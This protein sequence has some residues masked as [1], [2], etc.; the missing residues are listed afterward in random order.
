MFPLR[1]SVPRKIF[2]FWTIAIILA[3][4]Y[5]FFLEL[6]SGDP[7][8]FIKQYALVP[9][10][11]NFSESSALLPFVTS[12]FIH[13]GFLHV[14]ANMLFLWVFGDNVEERL[15]FLLFPIFYILAGVFGGL[16][17]YFFIPNSPIPIIGASG[18][19][20]GILGAYYILFPKSKVRTL[21]PIFIIPALVDIP[22]TVILVYW[23]VI[24]VFN[25]IASITSGVL[26][27]GGVAWFAHV[28]G[29]LLGL[30]TGYL[31]KK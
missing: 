20:A 24:Q 18:A 23:F 16:A 28:G 19:I 17:Q 22:A 14:G 27:L 8:T 26:A 2:P 12:L 29:F 7:D 9:I 31:A 4:I 10:N 5:I 11:V 21:V 15:G 1:D 3:N 6:I 30:F 13:G 25:G